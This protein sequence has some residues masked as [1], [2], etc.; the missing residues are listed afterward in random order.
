[1][2]ELKENFLKGGILSKFLQS[3]AWTSLFFAGS[4]LLSHVHLN[5]SSVTLILAWIFK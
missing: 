3:E 4:H 5:K 1:M 2:G